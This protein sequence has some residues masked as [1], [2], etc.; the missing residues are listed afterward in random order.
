MPIGTL[1]RK[2]QRQ[3]VMPRMVVL[4]GEEAADD[5]SEDARGAE[6]GQEV[7]LVLGALT[8]RHDVADDREGQR[9]ETAGAEALDGAEG[10][11]LP[12]DDARVQS[13]EP[14]MKIVIA[15]M[16]NGLRP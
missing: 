12:I 8:R 7:A 5:G 3:P 10:R 1:T 9:E 4:A 11:E 2:T 16:K 14:T 13:T 6:H 15:K